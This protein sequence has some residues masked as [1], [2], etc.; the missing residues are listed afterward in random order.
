LNR[1]GFLGSTTCAGFIPI[2]TFPGAIHFAEFLGFWTWDYTYQKDR[3]E[4]WF[5]LASAVLIFIPVLGLIWVFL[6]I[7]I[8]AII[9]VCVKPDSCYRQFPTK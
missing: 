5:G 6:G 1:E 4:F 2:P 9:D 3:T 7:R 8:W